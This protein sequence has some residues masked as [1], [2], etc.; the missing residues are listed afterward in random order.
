MSY[1]LDVDPVAQAQIRALPSDALIALAEVMSML[2][3]TPWSGRPI[4]EDNPQ[5]NVRVLPFGTAALITYL[6]LEDRRR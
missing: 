5:G 3:P 1:G 2:E 4:N 6:I